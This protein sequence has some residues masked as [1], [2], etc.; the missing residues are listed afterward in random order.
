MKPKIDHIQITVKD[1]IKAE[2][3]YDQLLPI[4]GF[5]LNKKGKGRVEAHDFDVIEYVR[6]DFII[7]FNSPREKYKNDDVHRRKPGSI[8]HLAFNAGSNANV[9]L[10]FQR[11]N[12][13]GAKIIETPKYFPQHGEKYYACFFKDPDGIK[14]EIMYEDK[15]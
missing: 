12:K 1:L 14:L 11:I 9:E 5:D 3:F 2:K 13:I 6:D 4:L 15:L 10:L 7:G 8:H